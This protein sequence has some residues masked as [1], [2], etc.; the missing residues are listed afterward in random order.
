LTRVMQHPNFAFLENEPYAWCWAACYLL[1][2]HA[3]S[4]SE[5]RDMVQ[6][7]RLTGGFSE[8]LTSQLGHVWPR[9]EENWQVF[10][11]S[12]EHGYD[13][14]RS[15]IRYQNTKPAGD[16]ASALV[17]TQ[18]G[19]QST[20]IELAPGKNYSISARGRYIIRNGE[21]PWPC[22]ANGVTIHYWKG[23]PLGV[24]TGAL[25]PTDWKGETT[26]T[27]TQPQ[28]IGPA[29]TIHPD[30]PVTLFLKINENPADLA[31][32]DGQLQIEVRELPDSSE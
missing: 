27:L 22:E 11:T 12:L 32:N 30:M 9:L 21:R 5:F 4:Q 24:L 10:A 1:D 31:D 28:P 3:L 7:V 14:Q 2:N 19:W 8:R 18:Y 26:T 16:F 20:G 29:N 23:L 6:H 25:R 15:Q 17:D 13:L